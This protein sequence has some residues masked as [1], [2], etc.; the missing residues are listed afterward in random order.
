MG[1]GDSREAEEAL[2]EQLSSEMIE[3]ED[4]IED[5]CVI[6]A[7]LVLSLGDFGER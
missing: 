3:D 4:D 2:D 1:G 5:N 6:L 7:G